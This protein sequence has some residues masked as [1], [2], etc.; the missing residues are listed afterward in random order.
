MSKQQGKRK[1]TS[2]AHGFFQENGQFFIIVSHDE[3]ILLPAA[4]QYTTI[5]ITKCSDNTTVSNICM[6][7]T[8]ELWRLEGFQHVLLSVAAVLDRIEQYWWSYDR[9]KV[10][11]V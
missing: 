2:N 10:S 4:H 6:N 7:M 5:I 1:Q 8:A 3:G 9:L 11:T